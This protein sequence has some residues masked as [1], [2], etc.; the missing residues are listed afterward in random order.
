VYL[1]FPFDL[2]ALVVSN[3]LMVVVH[4]ISCDAGGMKSSTRDRKRQ[5]KGAGRSLGSLR[6]LARPV[7]LCLMVSFLTSSAFAAEGLLATMYR[8]FLADGSPEV[9]VAFERETLVPRFP[10]GSQ[11]IRPS[12]AS[13]VRLQLQEHRDYFTFSRFGT[14]FIIS[15][16]EKHMLTNETDLTK[17]DGLSGF[18][19]AYYWSLSLD[20]PIRFIPKEQPETGPVA[21]GQLFN[22]LTLVPRTEAVHQEG[23]FRSAA[24]LAAI[25]GL[26]AECLS[27]IQCGFPGPLETPLHTADSYLV[28]TNG[29]GQAQRA[30]L[31]GSPFGPTEISFMESEAAKVGAT[32]DY[33]ADTLTV[34][35]STPM[36]GK[37][38]F[39]ARYRI[40]AFRVPSERHDQAFFSWSSYKRSAGN[41]VANL[42][43]NGATVSLEFKDM[44][45]FQPGHVLV[46][47]T[48]LKGRQAGPKYVIYL[49]F[50][51]V[52]ASAGIL[53]WHMNKSTK[54]TT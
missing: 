16:S 8:Q 1:I 20:N 28:L 44:L 53:L 31:V 46:Q 9:F 18:D 48:T 50:A 39:Q 4:Q 30:R 17:A 10:T 27:V 29:S 32:L 24:K 21:P 2:L 23:Q 37:I 36:D 41:V 38:F 3:R 43:T 7:S 19:G 54:S 33:D 15:Y 5:S 45:T 49:L 34:T 14:N 40:F 26:K 22:R 25:T 12:N 51:L 42:V 52:T 13:T 11:E 6:Y 35:R 47:P